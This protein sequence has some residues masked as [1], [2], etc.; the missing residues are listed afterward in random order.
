MGR[1]AIDFLEQ[2]LHRLLFD[3]MPMP[4]LLVDDNVSIL[5]YNSA[6]ARLLDKDKADVLNER[7]GAALCCIHSQEAS[8]G[9]GHSPACADCVIRQSVRAAMEGAHVARRTAS[10]ELLARGRSRRVEVRVSAHPLNYRH[11]KFVLLLLEDLEGTPR[12]AA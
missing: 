6:A 5:E 4:A 10:L 9:C 7:C 8:G 12:A 3:A 1:L 2:G 11:Q